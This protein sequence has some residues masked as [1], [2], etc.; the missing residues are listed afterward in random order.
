MAPDPRQPLRNGFESRMA[1]IRDVTRL[2]MVEAGDF[3]YYDD[4]SGP[5]RFDEQ[6][7]YA[8]GPERLVIGR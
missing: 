3:S 1:W 8:Y 7:L 2:S 6:V 4:P 5:E